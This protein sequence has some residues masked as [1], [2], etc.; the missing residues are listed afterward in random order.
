MSIP[1]GPVRLGCEGQGLN[2]LCVCRCVLAVA[3]GVCVLCVCGGRC[4]GRGQS[5]GWRGW[6]V[7]GGGRAGLGQVR[8]CQVSVCGGPLLRSRRHA[9]LLGLR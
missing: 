5:R 6:R 8:V 2:L 3:V 9:G 7:Q 1:V 4:G